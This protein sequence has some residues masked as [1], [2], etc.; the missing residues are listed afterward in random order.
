ME[1]KFIVTI[2]FEELFN[3]Q[4]K[5]RFALQTLE[6]EGEGTNTVDFYNNN[7]LKEF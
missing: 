2:N 1:I 5:W 7:L 6:W 3:F 4:S